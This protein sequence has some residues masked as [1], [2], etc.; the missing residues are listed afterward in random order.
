MVLEVVVEM[1]KVE[2]VRMMVEKVG[3]VVGIEVEIVNRVEVLEDTMKEV[4]G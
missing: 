3:E 4:G 2:V 1:M